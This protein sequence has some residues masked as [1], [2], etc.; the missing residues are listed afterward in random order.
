VKAIILAAG[1]ARRL[2]PLTQDLPKTLLRVG[3]MTILE[4]QVRTLRAAGIENITIVVGHHEDKVRQ[5]LG[6][7]VRYVHNPYFAATADIVSLWCARKQMIG[8]FLYLHGDVLFGPAI[9]QRLL[10]DAPAE[11]RLAIEA[12]ACDPEDEKVR[13]V[14]DTVIEISKAIAP[15]LAYGEFIGLA[16]ISAATAPALRDALETLVDEGDLETQCISAVQ[17][18]IDQGV[19]VQRTAVDGLPWCEIDYPD[20]LSAAVRQAALFD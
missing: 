4:R 13:V 17:R 7:T 9:L 3:A 12:K 19:H 5:A 15:A 1:Q 10:D 11:V 8:P 16:R 18:L 6:R 2:Y 14:G 20:D